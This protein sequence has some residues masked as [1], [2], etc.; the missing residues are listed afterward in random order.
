MVLITHEADI[1]E[2]GTRIVSFRDGTCA[3]ERWSR[4]GI[5]ADE[6][7]NL[8]GRASRMQA[9]AT[10][11]APRAA[12]GA[13]NACRSLMVFRVAFKALARNK[14]RTALTMLGM[15][16]GVGAVITMVALGTGAQSSIETQIQ[17]AGTNMIMV[18]AGNFMQGG[19]RMGQGNASTLTPDDALAIRD[20][21][22]RPV[23]RPGREH[24]RP[25]GRRQHE[26]G[27][28]DPGHR[29]RPAADPIVADEARRFFHVRWTSPPRQRSPSS[30]RSFTSNCSAPMSTPWAR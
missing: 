18:S 7:A 22:G 6:L 23:H 24:A 10:S 9:S 21:P 13:S 11:S 5:A 19:V 4:A 30:A 26:L 16:I 20:V 27:H 29:R 2:Y 8:P 28:A 14:M 17:A 3:S 12:G 15:I 1:A 25:G